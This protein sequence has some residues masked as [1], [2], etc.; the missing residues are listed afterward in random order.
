VDLERFL[1][2]HGW[3]PKNTILIIIHCN[4]TL[5][6]MAP[7]LMFIHSIGVLFTS[8]WPWK[9]FWAKMKLQGC[10]RVWRYIYI[11]IYLLMQYYWLLLLTKNGLHREKIVSGV[12]FDETEA[13]FWRTT[14]WKANMIEG[15]RTTFFAKRLDWQVWGEWNV[16]G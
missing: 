5:L 12:S 7:K 8:A 10:P 2:Y 11:Y 6:W 1:S 13:E 14:F 9:Q 3:T 16:R 4:H 15:E